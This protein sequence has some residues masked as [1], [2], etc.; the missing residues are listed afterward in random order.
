MSRTV[1]SIRCTDNTRVTGRQADGTRHALPLSRLMVNPLWHRVIRVVSRHRIPIWLKALF[2]IVLPTALK[3]WINLNLHFDIWLQLQS[4]GHTTRSNLCKKK[5][6]TTPAIKKV[7][8]ITCRINSSPHYFLLFDTSTNSII[9]VF[10]WRMISALLVK[11]KTL[12]LASLL[13]LA[14]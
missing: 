5:R 14:R 6:L 7:A 8:T 1:F 4:A 10:Y 9:T 13:N 2:S 12:P 11:C 3:H